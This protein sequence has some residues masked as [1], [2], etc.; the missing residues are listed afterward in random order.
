MKKLSIQILVAKDS[1]FLPYTKKLT[2]TLKLK[3]HK[4]ELV[5]S[6]RK[7]KKG[8]ILVI[9]SWPII[10]TKKILGFHKNNIVLHASALPKGKG[11]SPLSWQILEGKNK[12]PVTLF[13]AVER[14]DSGPIYLQD[15]IRFEGHELIDE[16]RRKL[17]MKIIEL[18]MKFID[19]YPNL[20]S[21]K[22][23]GKETF[24]K[25]RTP[26]D[27]EI[28][29]KKPIIKIFN[30]FRIVDNER[31]PT[32]FKYKGHKYILKIYKEKNEKKR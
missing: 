10:I 11:W 29:I 9:L 14:V 3:K 28:D 30:K 1:W 6:L 25:R 22:Q 2:K 15:T 18:V 27:S 32:F 4:V 20:V 19:N 12:I 21:K 17:A 13:E 16:L 26:K 23:R 31:Y 24:Y 8:N 7:I 5:T